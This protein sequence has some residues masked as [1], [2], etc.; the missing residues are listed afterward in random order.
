MLEK[1]KSKESKKE[2]KDERGKALEIRKKACETF[3]ETKKRHVY[4]GDVDDSEKPSG[5]GSGSGS[6]KRRTCSELFQLLVAR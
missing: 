4:E 1:I 6:K 3:A 5:S 2:R